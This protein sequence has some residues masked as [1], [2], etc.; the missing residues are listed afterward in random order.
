[1]KTEVV[2]SRRRKKTVEARLVDGILRV[3]LPASLDAAEEDHWVA[4]MSRRFA[5]VLR[6]EHVDLPNRAKQLARDLELPQPAEVAFSSRQKQ[7][8]GSCVPETGRIRISDRLIDF[9]PWVLDYVIV[10]EL[11]HLVVADHSVRF[12]QLVERYPLSERARGYLMAKET[13]VAEEDV[14]CA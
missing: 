11:A 10:H 4:V 7:R 3:Y 2:R 6:S 8:W 13:E 5:R 9:P 1:M 14:R 12:W